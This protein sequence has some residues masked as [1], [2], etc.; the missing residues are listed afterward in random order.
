MNTK[1]YLF[2]QLFA[3]HGRLSFFINAVAPQS[4]SLSQVTSLVDDAGAFVLL[5]NLVPFD[6]FS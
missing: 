4:L 6:T 1:L 5:S 3:R 2:S